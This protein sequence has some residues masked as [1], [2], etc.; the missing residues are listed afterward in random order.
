MKTLCAPLILVLA[1]VC[2]APAGAAD[3]KADLMAKEKASWIAWGKKDADTFGKFLDAGYRSVSGNEAPTVGKEANLKT[4]NANSC[5]VRNISF[6]NVA[7]RQLGQD[8]AVVAY[9]AA[10]DTTCKGKNQEEKVAV[11][12]VWHQQNGAWLNT[13]YH[14]SPIE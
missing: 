9:T 8:V 2:V 7:V 1:L 14:E 3:L 13:D 10:V 5:E 11:T 12:S 4:L 6:E